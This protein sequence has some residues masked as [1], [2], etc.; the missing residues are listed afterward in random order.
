MGNR[1]EPPDFSSDSD[2]EIHLIAGN[3]RDVSL[4]VRS[5]ET[6]ILQLAAQ[7]Q[8]QAALAATQ[9]QYI[10]ALQT[11]AEAQQEELDQVRVRISRLE[12]FCSALRQLLN[13]AHGP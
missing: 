1:E 3:V 6:T 8:Q 13:F 4:R 12:Q 5:A 2:D 11:S 10:S 7:F 9:Q